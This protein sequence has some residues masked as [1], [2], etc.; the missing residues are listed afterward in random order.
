MKIVSV[1]DKSAGFYSLYFFVVY[2]Y[3]VCRKKGVG[4]HLDS[5]HWL[6]KFKNGWTDYFQE[7][8][9]LEDLSPEDKT[10]QYFTHCENIMGMPLQFNMYEY[11]RVILDTL[12]LYN[13]T[14][15]QIIQDTNKRLEL[16]TGDY[17]AIFIRRGDK[18]CSES[19][20]IPTEEYVNT[21]LKKNPDCKTIF[22]QTDDYNCFLDIQAFIEKQELEIRVITLCHPSFKGGMVIFKEAQ[23]TNIHRHDFLNDP[24]HFQYFQQIVGHLGSTQTVDTMNPEQI[25]QHTVDLLVGV[26]IMLH[27]RWAVLDNQSNVSRFI[28]IIHDDPNY[29]VDVRFPDIPFDMERTLCPAYP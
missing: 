11:R 15:Q 2:N 1:L 26:D 14:V 8:Q 5:S 20:F 27:S 22:L 18:L 16:T 9:D 12:Y 29:V 3:L 10:I 19:L 21:L 23:N 4:F 13:D 7:I 25:Y 28:S 17:D 6:F 24:R